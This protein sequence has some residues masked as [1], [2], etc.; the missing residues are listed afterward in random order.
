MSQVTLYLD[1]DTHTRMRLA[2]QAA[3][4]STSRWLAELIRKHTRDEWPAAVLQ[5]AGA[6]ADAPTAEELR[7]TEGVDVPREPFE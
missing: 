1:D 7:A 4:L 3:G 2:A 5:L 6:W